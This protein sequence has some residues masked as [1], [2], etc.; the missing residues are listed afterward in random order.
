MIAVAFALPTESKLLVSRLRD[1]RRVACGASYIIYGKFDS[2][3][4]A[5][6]HTGVGRKISEMAMADFLR[7]Q[8]P[9]VLISSGFAGGA[10]TELKVGDLFLAENFSD[11]VLFSNSQ[12][13]LKNL[14]PQI[15]KLFTS[16]SI[17]DS[18]TERAEIAKAHGADA[19]DME[20]EGI[21]QACEQCRIPMLSLR[22]I[23]DT[24]HEPFPAPPSVLFDVDRQRTDFL[25]VAAHFAA[26]PTA[27]AAMFRFSRRIGRARQNLTEAL[28]RLLQDDSLGRAA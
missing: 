15:G 22:V 16:P 7:G 3:S 11:R 4:L 18:Q 13:A 10:G 26:R 23:T 9:D 14:D 1:R 12:R 24:P 8:R 5:I 21:V 25:E 2:R 6:L 27:L 28:T 19:I 20:T 17:V